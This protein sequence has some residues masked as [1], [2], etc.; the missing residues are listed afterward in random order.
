MTD[1]ASIIELL[2]D[3]CDAFNAHDIDRIMSFFAEDC[4]LQMPRGPA[5]C[6]RRYDGKAA[7]REGPAA[8]LAGLPDVNYGHT[9]H[10]ACGDTGISKWTISGTTAS[11]ELI[12]ALVATSIRSVRA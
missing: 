9:N 12:E 2:E 7:V 8:R 3:I 11:G 5:P 10:Y 1:P 4:I 6:G